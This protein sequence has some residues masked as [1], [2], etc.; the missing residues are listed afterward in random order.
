[1]Y[2]LDLQD[3]E[4]AAKITYYNSWVNFHTKKPSIKLIKNEGKLHKIYFKPFPLSRL[5]YY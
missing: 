2:C 5:A 3:R 1:M 4:E